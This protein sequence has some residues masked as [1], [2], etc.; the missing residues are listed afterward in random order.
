MWIQSLIFGMIMMMMMI[1]GGG[2][3][4]MRWFMYGLVMLM[5]IPL[6]VSPF[7][8]NVILHSI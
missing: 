2:G 3:G 1:G 4:N 8:S 5:M 7:R 6:L